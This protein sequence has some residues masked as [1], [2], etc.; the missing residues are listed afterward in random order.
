MKLQL[1]RCV[2][3][4]A[5]AASAVQAQIVTTRV[6]IT[7]GGVQPNGYCIDAVISADG[8]VAAFTSRAN[9]LDAADTNSVD[10]VYVADLASGALELVSVN[11][12]GQ[13]GD[14]R[15]GKASLSRDGRYVVFHSFADNLG[16]GALASS[17]LYLR[18]RLLGVTELL[19]VGLGGSPTEG[20]MGVISADAGFVVFASSAADLVASDTNGLADIFLIDRSAGTTERVNLGAGGAELLGGSSA[21]PTLS[22]DGRFIVFES[23]AENVLP[24]GVAGYPHLFL[25]DRQSGATERLNVSSTG[26]VGLGSFGPA[27]ATVSADGRFVAFTSTAATLV[28]GDANS[29]G[30]VFLRDRLL[31]QTTLE[32]NTHQGWINRA[33]PM[34]CALSQD[35]RTLGFSTTYVT[36]VPNPPRHVW[37]KNLSTGFVTCASVN[38]LNQQGNRQSFDVALSEDGTRVVFRSDATNL[39]PNDTN[40]LRDVFLH[41]LPTVPLPTSFCTA[42]TNSLGCTPTIT[43]SGLPSA[44]AGSG[45]II[46]AQQVLP[47]MSG[48]LRYS[49]QGNAQPWQG[50]LICTAA[51]NPGRTWPQTASASGAPP[52]TGEYAFDFN[53]FIASGVNPILIAGQRVFVQYYMRDPASTYG[54]GLSNG[55]DFTI[56]P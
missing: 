29:Q 37:L 35:G 16:A 13:A 51:G 15:S 17:S 23:W 52:C 43:W 49:S 8:R 38:G 30:D 56:L 48:A 28:A 2:A 22:P 53:Q 40:S 25:I 4:L 5:C 45:F 33:L 20:S 12:S 42:K 34:G 47:H 18:D 44:S 46:G 21:R 31:G 36:G 9:N 55:L 19:S 3:A 27:T 24:G 1:V 14:D 32:T 26:V 54:W 7:P 6:S 11:A 39:V 50:G 41:E 10:D